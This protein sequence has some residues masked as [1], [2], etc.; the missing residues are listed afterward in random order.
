[1]KLSSAIP[2]FLFLL[3]FPI[4]VLSQDSLNLKKEKPKEHP[5][6]DKLVFGGN[7]GLMIGTVTAIDF[8]PIIG[9]YITPK[10]ISG[11]GLSYSYYREKNIY[12]EIKSHIYGARVFS[13]YTFLENI[14]ADLPMKANF[15]LFAHA[16]YEALNLDRSFNS[17][18]ISSVK[19]RYW[20]HSPLI[21]GGFKQPI[22]KKSSFNITILYNLNYQ[23]NLPYA[24]PIIRI[25]FYF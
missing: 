7:L 10:L 9:Y 1:M 3:L 24:N 15:A 25:G 18:E 17:N 20:V 21:G 23:D 12:G 5:I 16:E 8:S 6:K 11:I 13:N 2:Y 22:G 4:Q 19:E 14:G